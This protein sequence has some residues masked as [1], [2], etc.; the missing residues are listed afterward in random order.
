M[1]EANED[2]HL[3][4]LNKMDIWVQIYDLPNAMLSGRILQS[5]GNSVGTSVKSDF[6]N[7]N[8]VWKMF[9][10]IRFIMDVDKQ[11]KKRMKIKLVEDAWGWINFKYE[12]ISTFCFIF[13]LMGHSG[14]RV[15]GCLC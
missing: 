14:R 11:L 1:L 8:G 2:P 6:S 10:R 9:M 3:V 12:M 15:W 13:G 5:I 7:L 4:K